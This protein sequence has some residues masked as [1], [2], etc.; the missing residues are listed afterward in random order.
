MVFGDVMQASGSGPLSP[1]TTI[2]P[3]NPF[4]S[5]NAGPRVSGMAAKKLKF[6]IGGKK[7]SVYAADG[8]GRADAGVQLEAGG[9]GLKDESM[10][11]TIGGK[12]LTEVGRSLEEGEY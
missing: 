4:L 1:R 10:G 5:D 6:T 3:P 7:K 9:M 11:L 8:P 2:P 12:G